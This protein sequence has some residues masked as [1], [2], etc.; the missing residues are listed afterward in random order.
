MILQ[1]GSPWAK[2]ASNFLRDKIGKKVVY[3]TFLGKDL[4]ERDI[5]EV[6]L[7]KE[8]K[9][10]VNKMLLQEG[11]A[12]SERY[13]NNDGENT[14]NVVQ[15]VKNEITEVSAKMQGKG[16]WGGPLDD[17]GDEFNSNSVNDFP[18]QPNE[19]KENSNTKVKRFP[20]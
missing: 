2:E 20:K 5:V 13:S 7:D 3:L 10:N 1:K 15:Y 18:E 14:H 4:Y 17:E 16:M 9:Q 6:Y 8:K 12:S 11:L 19:P